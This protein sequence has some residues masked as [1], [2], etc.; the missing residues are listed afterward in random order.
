MTFLFY[1]FNIFMGIFSH[2]HQ[3]EAAQRVGTQS[4]Q[5]QQQLKIW[6]IILHRL[7]G[8]GAGLER[9]SE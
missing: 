6:K 9:E 4:W 1:R 7:K 5:Q 3:R 2:H 8:I